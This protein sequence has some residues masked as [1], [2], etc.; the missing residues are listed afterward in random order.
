[1]NHSGQSIAAAAK[2]YKI[3]P[4]RIVVFHDELALAPSKMRVKLGGGAAGHNG[5]RSTE[6]HMGSPN[7][8]RVRLGIGHPGNK[9]DVSNFVLSDFSKT[10]MKWVE[11]LVKAVAKHAVLMAEG[12]DGDFMTKVA[13]E[14]QPPKPKKE[15]PIQI[16][17]EE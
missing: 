12:N 2:F 5:I 9:D 8:W 3:E 13:A 16:E 4:E 15:K 7:F 6:A 1:M 17:K 14:L 11:H 10:E